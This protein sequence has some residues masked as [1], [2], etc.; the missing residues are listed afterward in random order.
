LGREFPGVEH[1]PGQCLDELGDH[2]FHYVSAVLVRPFGT[3]EPFGPPAFGQED[4]SCVVGRFA[5]NLV[6]K[7]KVRR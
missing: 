5:E 1:V 3:E 4:Q 6:I 7:V 2:R